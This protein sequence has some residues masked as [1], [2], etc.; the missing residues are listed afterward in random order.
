MILLSMKCPIYD[1]LSMKCPIAKSQ[2]NGNKGNRR[3]DLILY[4]TGGKAGLVQIIEQ[5]PYGYN[6]YIDSSFFK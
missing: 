2:Q 1:L 4:S 3:V 6:I 5:F